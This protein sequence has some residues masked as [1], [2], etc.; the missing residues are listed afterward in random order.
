MQE[1]MVPERT[2]M[3]Q[4]AVVK[5]H[6]DVPSRDRVARRARYP[7]EQIALGRAVY[8]LRARRGLSQE[9]LGF[10]SGLHRNYVGAIERG[11]QNIT[12]RLLLKLS[13]GLHLPLSELIRI[14]ERNRRELLESD[15]DTEDA[16]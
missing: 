5:P 8:E 4:R 13:R 11:E 6:H 2:R 1:L 3:R 14:F 12:F 16:R 9:E 10:Q 7:P 15:G